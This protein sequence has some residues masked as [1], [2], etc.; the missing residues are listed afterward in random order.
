MEAP[1]DERRT[2]A[3][4]AVKVLGWSATVG[5]GVDLIGTGGAQ[6]LIEGAKHGFEPQAH[7][8]VSDLL[9]NPLTYLGIVG[10]IY[11]LTKGVKAAKSKLPTILNSVRAKALGSGRHA[12]DHEAGTATSQESKETPDN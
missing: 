4:N 12:R 2:F 10:G 1:K 3:Q 11:G 7:F 6:L 8:V 5:A 9:P